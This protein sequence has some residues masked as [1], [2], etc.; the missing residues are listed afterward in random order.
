MD[1]CT[2]GNHDAPYRGNCGEGLEVSGWKRG[3]HPE[4]DE[5]GI[6][7]D[8]NLIPQA[9]GWLAREDKLIIGLEKGSFPYL[10]LEKMN[11]VERIIFDFIDTPFPERDLNFFWP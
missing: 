8:P 5:K 3:G 6:K 9:I 10:F 7:A 2:G 4:S 1:I 11:G